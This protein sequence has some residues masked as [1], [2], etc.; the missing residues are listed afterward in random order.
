MRPPA[1][2]TL[3]VRTASSPALPPT[4]EGRRKSPEAVGRPILVTTD[5]GSLQVLR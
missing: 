4:P 3:N 1:L 5:W 2:T